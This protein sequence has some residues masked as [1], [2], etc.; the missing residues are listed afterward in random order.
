MLDSMRDL[1]KLALA[2]MPPATRV[3]PE[4]AE[5]VLRH[6]DLLLSLTDD[7]VKGFYDTL[8]EH[9]ETNKVFVE[10]ERSMREQTLSDWW[11]RTVRGPLNDD[12]WA[13]MALVG[14]THVIRRVSNPMMLA[15][16]GYV[17]QF[18]EERA[19]SFDM[20]DDDRELLIAAFRRVASMVSA[21]ITYSYDRAISTAL[22][23]VVGMP[24]AL[25]TRLQDQEVRTALERAHREKA[26]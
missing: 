3:L 16:A 18:V 15:M 26:L 24:E 11:Q 9:P 23:E 22:F 12:Y 7:V 21:I 4:H 20:A 19:S 14:L 8:Y 10:G 13:W 5:A 2:D 17:A 6:Q 25:L 1:A